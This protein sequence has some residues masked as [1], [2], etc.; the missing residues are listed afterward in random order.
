M[1]ELDF[2]QKFKDLYRKYYLLSDIKQAKIGMLVLIIPIIMYAFNDFQFFGLSFEFYSLISLRIV[3]VLSVIILLIYLSNIKKY[4]TYDKTIFIWSLFAIIITTIINASRPNNFLFQTIVILSIF[5]VIY[6]IIPQKFANRL[7][8]SLVATTGGISILIRDWAFIDI[9]S[10]FSIL[11]SFILANILGILVSR[12][13][14]KYR[15]RSFKSYEENRDLVRILS[16]S[17]HIVMRISQENVVLYANPAAKNE[18]GTS[19]IETGKSLP[20]FIQLNHSKLV[21]TEIT[22]K[23]KTYLFTVSPVPTEGYSNVYA[24]DISRRKRNESLIQLH[25]RRLNSLLELNMM[26]DA[27]DKELLDFSLEAIKKITQ[28]KFGLIGFLNEADTTLT[29]ASW[30]KTVLEECEADDKSVVF[31]TPEG[32]LWAEPIKQRKP[33]IIDDYSASFPYKKGLPEGHLKITSWLGVPIFEKEKIVA[34]AAV[35]NKKEPYTQLDVLSITRM[36]SDLWRLIQRKRDSQKLQE[37]AQKIEIMN[38]KLR[39]SGSLVRHDVRNKLSIITGQS[40]LLK[41]KCIGHP[42][43]VDALSKMDQAAKDSSKIFDFAKMYEQLGVEKLVY[44]NTEKALNDALTLFSGLTFKV[45]NSCQGL[46]LLAD[47]FL[48]QLFYNFLDN[49]MK[50]GQKTTSVKVYFEKKDSGELL[51]MYED[52]GVGI[53]AENKKYLFTEG[54]STGGSSGFG[55]FLILRMMEVYGWKIREIGEEN[56]GV[57]FEIIIPKVNKEGKDNYHIS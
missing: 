38:E 6:F 25:E 40:Y 18:F 49:T 36:I 56:K 39:V 26:L 54:F 42:E 11:F 50:Y 43:V 32:G 55:L 41:K 34:L 53:S 23:D 16:E 21:E 44:I 20:S 13:I 45:V 12:I 33:I 7:I 10:S 3:F 37:N 47:S 15:L 27:S 19:E 46:N 28:S 52:D 51:L 5:V 9:P 24:R 22:H 2:P 4:N 48:R 14:D 1:V 30:S 8:L 57:K 35:A 31:S 29:I 17:P